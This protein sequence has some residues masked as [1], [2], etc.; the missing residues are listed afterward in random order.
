MKNKFLAHI[1]A[2]FVCV[3][4]VH[5]Y[6]PGHH[7]CR[8]VYKLYLT[9]VLSTKIVYMYKNNVYICLIY[10]NSVIYIKIAPIK[11][12]NLYKINKSTE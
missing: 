9:V 1:R 11:E 6:I 10:K 7:S 12:K 8:C 3:Y 5:T 2:R 4:D